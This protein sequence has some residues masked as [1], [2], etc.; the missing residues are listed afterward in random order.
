MWLGTELETWLRVGL[1]L[2]VS[3]A[4]WI[5]WY[6]WWVVRHPGVVCCLV[7]AQL[8][9]IV[10][11]VLS[12]LTLG[13]LGIL[14][15]ETLIAVNLTTAGVVFLVGI[16]PGIGKIVPF[17]RAL[18]M[19]VRA[20]GKS[21]AVVF[22]LVLFAGITGWNLF[23]GWF[24]PPREWDS[25]NYH[26]PIM[27]AF[28]Q[29]HAI[30]PIWSPLGWIRGYPFNGELLQLWTL[31]AVGVDK[32]VDW[33]FVPS[34]LAGALA[35]YGLTRSLGAKPEASTLGAAVFA[36]APRVLLQQTEAMVDALF[37]SIIAM[38]LFM[39]L[40]ISNSPDE[41]RPRRM[42]LSAI[43]AAASAGLLVGIKVN[44][45]VFALG[46]LA[47]FWIRWIHPVRKSVS[48]P[49]PSGKEYGWARIVV[50]PLLLFLG[51]CLYPYLRDWAYFGN[52]V[53][54][55]T[56]QINGVVLFPGIR[57]FS[58]V[59]ESNTVEQVKS[60]GIVGR[61][62]YPW[63]EPYQSVHDNYL[64]GLGPLWIVL[65]VPALLVWIV[66]LLHRRRPVEIILVGML[67]GG[68]VVTPVF[69]YPRYAIPLLISGSLAVG[70]VLDGLSRWPRRMIVAV[71]IF[72]SM[73]SVFNTLAPKS[74][75][76]KDAHDV[77]LA[78]DDLTR[79]G[80]QFVHPYYGRAA[81]EWIDLFSMSRSVVVSYGEYVYFPYLLY[82]TDIRNRVVHILPSS[83]G[84][85]GAALDKEQ[86]EIVLV[87]SDMTTYEWI[88]NYPHY[89]EVF[90]DGVYVV[91]ERFQ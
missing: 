76:W 55:H 86:V 12:V 69:W 20:R 41:D 6:G 33:A 56:I 89:Q 79:S 8:F 29:S 19:D 22:L 35:V 39:I 37:A 57:D 63:F 24:L 43:G 75:S 11:I 59:E 72:L 15:P 28:Y 70:L 74:V 87:R 9:S 66:R 83:D 34:I 47:L 61:T 48:T 85:W 52:P 40:G 7:G 18:W 64:G 25:I 32:L 65:G 78:Q 54:P 4:V 80:P 88:V 30:T 3:F 90:R 17:H 53:Y 31:A 26:L 16:R 38:G 2:I 60:M 42:R 73:F 14:Y 81:Y 82:G 51:L 10:Q 45:I 36:F 1:L 91:F 67:L 44:G 21:I 68:V 71:I 58:E 50:L 27:A 46:I 13:L 5:C 84:E 77:L 23:W 62:V 49:A